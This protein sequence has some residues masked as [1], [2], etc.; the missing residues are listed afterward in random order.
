MK[1][2]DGC[3]RIFLAPPSSII[4]WE[5]TYCNVI[6]LCSGGGGCLYLGGGG[7]GG[8][9][10]KDNY[11]HTHTRLHNLGYAI[12]TMEMYQRSELVNHFV[13]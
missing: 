5:S 2:E 6:M 1:S 7:G 13:I 9:V 8:A 10:Q 3:L 11:I 12:K 4:M